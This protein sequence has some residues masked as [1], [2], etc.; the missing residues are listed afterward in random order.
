[1]NTVSRLY[2]FF[3][4]AVPLFVREETNDAKIPKRL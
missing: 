2:P 3:I 1:M 4:P